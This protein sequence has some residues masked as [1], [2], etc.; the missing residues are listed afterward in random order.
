LEVDSTP[1]L[2]PTLVVFAV[3]A[4]EWHSS[5]KVALAALFAAFV[6]TV[7]C[8]HYPGLS[9]AEIVAYGE[10]LLAAPV[11]VARTV[12]AGCFLYSVVRLIRTSGIPW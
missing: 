8:M 4:I 12:G 2:I 10:D 1:L 3:V 11:T 7:A 9:A 5:R 6:L